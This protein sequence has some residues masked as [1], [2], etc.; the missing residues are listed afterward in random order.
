MKNEDDLQCVKSEIIGQWYEAKTWII[1]I[2]WE[3]Q[4][5]N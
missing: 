5:E 3:N 4:Y 1:I 2:D